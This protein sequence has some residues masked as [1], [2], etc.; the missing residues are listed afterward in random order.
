MQAVPISVSAGQALP[1]L[2]RFR[3]VHFVCPLRANTTETI[4]CITDD[5]HYEE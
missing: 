2:R 1:R 3:V 5:L 4:E